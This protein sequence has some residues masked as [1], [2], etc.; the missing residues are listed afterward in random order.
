M[1]L[2]T[3]QPVPLPLTVTGSHGQMT[4]CRTSGRVLELLD[5]ETG[6]A[7]YSRIVRVDLKELRAYYGGGLDRLTILDILDVG[8]WE[9]DEYGQLTYELPEWDWREG[10]WIDHF[11]RRDPMRT[12]ILLH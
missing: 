9:T 3:H 12:V 10:F 6:E 4:I 11:D 2:L 8:Y 7:D 1:K 5:Y